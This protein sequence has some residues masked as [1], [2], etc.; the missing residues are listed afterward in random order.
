M[1]RPRFT[2]RA[3][4]E[5]TKWVSTD[6]EETFRKNWNNSDTRKELIKYGYN[7]PKCIYYY[8]DEYGFRLVPKVNYNPYKVILTLGDSN[9]FGVGLPEKHVWTWLL[10]EA[11]GINVFN[12]AVPGSSTDTAFRISRELIPEI[13][14]TAVFHLATYD[15]RREIISDH[16]WCGHPYKFGPWADEDELIATHTEEEVELVDAFSRLE[17]GKLSTKLNAEKNRLAIARICYLND[18]PYF[19]ILMDD[20]NEGQYSRSARD[21]QH[22]GYTFQQAIATQM[23]RKFTKNN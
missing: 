17:S 9:T 12:A 15:N 3:G 6:S 23:Y 14:P 7:D 10:S 21:L 19:E 8:F 1:E 13:N 20:T 11:I 2:S 18:I 22:R 4:L 16:M 5:K